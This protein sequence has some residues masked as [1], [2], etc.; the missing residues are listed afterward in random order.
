[1][2]PDRFPEK[3]VRRVAV[4]RARLKNSQRDHVRRGVINNDLDVVFAGLGELHISETLNS[5]VCSIGVCG[6]GDL[7]LISSSYLNTRS[8]L[9]DNSVPEG[10][11]W[12]SG[13]LGD[14]VEQEVPEG[15]DARAHPI[16][17]PN[18]GDLP[19]G[20]TE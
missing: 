14:N 18:D 12:V 20:I 1:M 15:K 8:G 5:G 11:S 13:P 4:L 9:E 2:T 10:L 3:L 16:E 17:F 7:D 6:K 19:S